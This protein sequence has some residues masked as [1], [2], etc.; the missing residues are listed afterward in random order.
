MP[1]KAR[2]TEVFFFLADG[3]VRRFAQ[4]LYASLARG[5]VAMTEFASKCLRVADWYVLYDG[6]TAISID[7]ETYLIL[8]FDEAGHARPHSDMSCA[9]PSGSPW[10]PTP[11]Q[12][13][14]LSS[15]IFGRRDPAPH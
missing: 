3:S 13:Q 8:W 14:R 4:P 12:R 6:E 2:R 5:E 11:A 7:N 10:T 15:I 9:P 1:L